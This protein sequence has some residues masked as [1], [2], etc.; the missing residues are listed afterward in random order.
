LNVTISSSGEP[1]VRGFK[2]SGEGTTE[3]L[4]TV[5]RFAAEKPAAIAF[6]SGDG[7]KLELPVRS[8]EQR[9]TLIWDDGASRTFPF[10]RWQREPKLVPAA[11]AVEPAT[12]V[13]LAPA[14]GSKLPRLPL[15][16]PD[17]KR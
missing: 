6:K 4:N 10:D 1:E 5:Y 15:L 16:L 2:L 8:G 3:G 13:A 12:G 9:F 11:G 14:F 17:V 7:L